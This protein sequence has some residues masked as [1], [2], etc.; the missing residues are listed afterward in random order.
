MKRFVA[1]LLVAGFIAACS[2]STPPDSAAGSAPAAA[3][4]A[5]PAPAA[6]ADPQPAQPAPTPAEQP[7]PQSATPAAPPPSQSLQPATTPA[8]PPG[9]SEARPVT[10]GVEPPPPPPAPRP[11]EPPPAPKFREVTVPAGTEISVKILNTLASNTSKVED[12]VKGSVAKSVVVSEATA[13]PAGSE[14]SGTVIEANESG[15]VKGKASIAIRFDRITVRG[16]SIG[17]QTARVARE[18]AQNKKDDVKKGGIG[19]GLGAAVGGIVGGGKGAAIGA[20]AG[21]AGTVMATKGDEVQIAPGTIVTVL[22][23]EPLTLSVPVK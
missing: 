21:G 18:A 7:A 1:L 9:R 3:P 15:R 17:V 8:T 10:A 22:L 20:V 14:L 6:Q 19:A 13:I 11:P 2:Q 5:S 4:A 23:Q 12:R 16:E